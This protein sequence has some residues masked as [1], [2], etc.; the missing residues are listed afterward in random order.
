LLLLLLL[1]QNSETTTREVIRMLLAKFHIQDN[2][3]KFALYE[4][5][6]DQDQGLLCFL[7]LYNWPSVKLW[8]H[9]KTRCL[10]CVEC[11]QYSTRLEALAC[12]CDCVSGRVQQVV[13]VIC[14]KAHRRRRQMVQCYSTGAS[15]VSSHEGT[16]ALP[17]E[18]DWTCAFFG[19]LE[20]TTETANGSVQ[21]FLHS[22]RHKVPILYNGRPYPPEMPFPMGIWTSHVTHDALGLCEPKTETAPRSVQPCLRRWPQSVPIWFACFALKIVPSLPSHVGIW[23]PCNTWFIE[24]TRVRNANGNLIVSALFAGL[25]SVTDW[26]I[27]LKHS[28]CLYKLTLNYSTNPNPSNPNPNHNSKP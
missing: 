12:L 6:Q 17:G 20:S 27:T 21:P 13:T 5:L 2:P 11:R 15:N 22:L 7:I 3:G 23:T 4:Q 18:Y 9:V 14:H 1:L 19:P 24:P 25:T 8:F 28:T 16:L 26:Q 10:Y